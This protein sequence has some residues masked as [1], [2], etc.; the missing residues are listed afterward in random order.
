MNGIDRNL[1]NLKGK[2]AIVCGSSDGIGKATALL[3]SNAG[4]EIVIIARNREKL[5]SLA[6]NLNSSFGRAHS[7]LIADFNNPLE[8]QE[9]LKNIEPNFDILVNNSGGPPVGALIDA[10]LNDFEKAFKRHLICNQV[11][12]QFVVP[13]MIKSNNGRIVNII[14]TS[15]KQV[16]PNLGVSNTIRGAVAYWGKTLAIELGKNNIT[17]NNVLPGYTNTNRLKQLAEDKALKNGLNK[18][19]I[20]SEWIKSVPLSRIGEPDEIAN[21]ILFLCSDMSSFITGVD[22]PVD[23]GRYG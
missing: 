4:A 23:G 7:I 3:L 10:K 15:V 1:I 18:A 19:D 13:G 16:I 12:A 9:E 22:I 21:V 2:R 17:V 11:L 6:N 14:S 5:K 20:Y 8:L